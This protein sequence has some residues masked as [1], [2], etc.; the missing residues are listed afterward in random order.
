MPGK[1]AGARACPH[2]P[3]G[4]ESGEVETGEHWLTCEAYSELRQG[5]NPELCVKDRLKYLRLV[6]LVR[7]ELEK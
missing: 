7:I 5:L 3:A 4:R 6:Q 2:C 1:Y